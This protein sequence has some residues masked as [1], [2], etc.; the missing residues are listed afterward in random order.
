MRHM[1]VLSEAAKRLLHQLESGFVE[2]DNLDREAADELI[3][4][5][6]AGIEGNTLKLLRDCQESMPVSPV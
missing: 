1:I 5:V 4:N 6:L 3:K 2:I